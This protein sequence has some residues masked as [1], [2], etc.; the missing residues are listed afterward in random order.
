MPIAGTRVTVPMVFSDGTK[1]CCAHCLEPIPK[2]LYLSNNYGLFTLT[3][4]ASPVSAGQWKGSFP[5]EVDNA[6]GSEPDPD[7]TPTTYHTGP[8]RR[9]VN[10]D[11]TDTVVVTATVTC[12]DV[13][14]GPWKL[15]YSAPALKLFSRLVGSTFSNANNCGDYSVETVLS[16][17]VNAASAGCGTTQTFPAPSRT[18]TGPTGQAYLDCPDVGTSGLSA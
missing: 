7:H 5:A 6:A 13:A 11:I 9:P 1:T 3:H 16:N 2:T 18:W 4:V 12:P 15:R 10:G 14:G 17:S 8:C